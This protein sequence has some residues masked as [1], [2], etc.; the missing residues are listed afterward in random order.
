MSK[1]KL[2]T[3]QIEKILKSEVKNIN[4][5]FRRELKQIDIPNQILDLIKKGISPVAGAIGR[6]KKYA[7]SYIDVIQGKAKYISFKTGKVVRIEPKLLQGEQTKVKFTKT[8]LV[9]GKTQKAKYEKFEKGLGVGKRISP[10]NFKVSGE[11]HEG[12][13]YNESTGEITAERDANG[14]NLWQIHNDGEGK[15][16]ER[17]LLPTRK[18]ERFNRR[19]DQKIT[20]A[21]AKVLGVKTSKLKRFMKVNFNIRS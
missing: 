2:T 14:Y 21:L 6:F 1:N 7:Q 13:K 10:V 12:L 11:M 20:E 5:L 8:G 17:R 9:Q 15:L 18:G 3:G 4:K 16:P 19:I